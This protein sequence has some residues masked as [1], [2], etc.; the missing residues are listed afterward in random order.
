[1]I[2][3][4]RYIV[5]HGTKLLRALDYNQVL[6]NANGF[7]ADFQRAQSN[8]ALS[9]AANGSYNGAYNPAI[10]GSQQ[11]TVFPLLV[12]P[13]FTNA[14][15]QTYLRQGQIGELANLYQTNRLNGGVNFYRNPNI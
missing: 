8:A 5:N 12:N 4:A 2:C 14:T 1:M 11:L 7:L 10:P 9:Q 13:N 15:V 6:Y 3:E